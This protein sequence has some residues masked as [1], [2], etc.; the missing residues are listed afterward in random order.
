MTRRRGEARLASPCERAIGV[1][2]VILSR[3][4]MAE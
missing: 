1:G 2:K 3:E 4:F